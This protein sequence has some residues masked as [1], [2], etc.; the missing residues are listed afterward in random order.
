[1]ADLAGDLGAVLLDR[2]VNLGDGGLRRGP[3]RE[4]L[5]NVDDLARHQSCPVRL[6]ASRAS[7]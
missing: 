7:T 6:A 2:S 4:Q 3:P 1:M 5:V